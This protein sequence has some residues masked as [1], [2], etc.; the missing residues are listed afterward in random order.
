MPFT[1]LKAILERVMREQDF[2]GDIE[3]YR[4]FSEWTDIVGQKVAGHTRPVRLGD[5]ILYVEVDDHLWL[6]QLK[7][8]KA[9]MLRKIDRAIKPGLFR[10]LKFFLKSVQ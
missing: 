3:A 9:D 1:I 7:Y 10:D 4:V 6:A 5:R 8:M 2:K